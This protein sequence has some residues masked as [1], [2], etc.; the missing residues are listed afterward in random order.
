MSGATP[1]EAWAVIEEG[2]GLN[3]STIFSTE[4]DARE[5]SDGVPS[6]VVRVR[7]EIIREADQ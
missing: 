1:I 5:W 2:R 7:I 6:K 4:K 3:I